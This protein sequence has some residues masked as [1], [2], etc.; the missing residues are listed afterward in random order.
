MGV[1]LEG[2]L[3]FCSVLGRAFLLPCGDANTYDGN[4]PKLHYFS[5]DN[6]IATFHPD[7]FGST[8]L[9]IDFN[10]CT[11][12]SIEKFDRVIQGFTL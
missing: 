4:Q 1:A 8:L 11:D 7:T 3:D 5:I 12:F 10:F 2:I 6:E 9:G